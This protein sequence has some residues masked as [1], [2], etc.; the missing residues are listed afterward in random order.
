MVMRFYLSGLVLVFLSSAF[1]KLQRNIEENDI[2]SVS[3]P[4]DKVLIE[5]LTFSIENILKIYEEAQIE[6][7]QEEILHHFEEIQEQLEDVKKS[8]NNI[9]KEM[10]KLGITVGYSKEEI[11]IVESLDSYRYYVSHPDNSDLQ[12]TF[13]EK[14]GT[15]DEHIRVLMHGLLHDYVS[16]PDIM[17]DMRDILE[18]RNK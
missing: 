12:K 1:A 9:Q 18:V 11:A 13:I 15:L 17:S 2:F 6:K 7:N 5:L 4:E 16:N 14:A 3:F 8:I 10:K